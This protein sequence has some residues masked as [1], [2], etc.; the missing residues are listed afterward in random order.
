MQEET[1][2][3]YKLFRL[4][5]RKHHALKSEQRLKQIIK[6]LKYYQGDTVIQSRFGQSIRLSA[7]N[8][9]FGQPN[10]TL[11]LRNGESKLN[12]EKKGFVSVEEDINRD[13]STI[14]MTS[15]KYKSRFIP[16]SVDKNGKSD[17]KLKTWQNNPKYGLED[18]PKE[19]DGNQII[20]TSERLIFSSRSKE[21]FFFSKGWFGIT[22]DSAFSVDSN[23]GVNIVSHKNNIDIE[24]KEQKININ[25][26][27]SGVINLGS[28]KELSPIIDG[29]GLHDLLQD[30]IDITNNICRG[31]LLTPAGTSTGEKPVLS[32][33]LMTLRSKV[34]GLLSKTVFAARK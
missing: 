7:Y 1:Q 32:K 6:R 27:K 2:R 28:S 4:G 24:A 31:G 16:G 9:S 13:G 21:T 10:P 15:G 18:Y 34:P 12:S 3:K 33:Q 5:I 30:L 20:I 22:T 19:L 25:A 29:K 8:N 23:G 11:I 14:S 26:G 17:F